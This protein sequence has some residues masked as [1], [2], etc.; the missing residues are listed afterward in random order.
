[1]FLTRINKVVI[2]IFLILISSL[3]VVY[4]QEKPS[5]KKPVVEGEQV[6]KGNVTEEKNAGEVVTGETDRSTDAQGK[7]KTKEN[8]KGDDEVKK[9]KGS[10][11]DM[12]KSRGARPPTV[13]RPSGSRTPKGAGK[14]RGAGGPGKR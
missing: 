13:V 3:R 12:S 8:G 10:S 5:G 1:M 11:L 7:E 6:E 9:V 14:P 2:L 4:A